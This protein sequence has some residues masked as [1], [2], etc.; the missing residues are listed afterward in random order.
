[1]LDQKIWRK[2]SRGPQ[3]ILPKDAA[4]I[5]ALTGLQSGDTVVDAGAGSGWLAIYLG[6]IV[7]PSGKVVSYE[8]REDFAALAEKNAKKAGLEGVVEIRKADVFAGIAERGVDLVTLDFAESDKAVAHA[9]AALKPG[10][11]CVGYHPNVEQV[12]AFVEAGEAAG[13]AHDQTVECMVR[14]LLVRK[15][16]CRPQT[17]GIMHTGYLTFLKKPAAEALKPKE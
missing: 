3:V 12:K 11:W 10:G 14:E 15:Q 5:S 9:F 13:F 16:G 17:T 6:S 4:M 7:A 8:W 2:L 1:M